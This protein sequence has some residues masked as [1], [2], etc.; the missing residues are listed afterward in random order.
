MELLHILQIAWYCR[1]A[2]HLSRLSHAF[3]LIAA[4]LRMCVAVRLMATAAVL[5][6]AVPFGD[7]DDGIAPTMADA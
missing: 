5:L 3:H 7:D 2:G 1:P 6:N 4:W